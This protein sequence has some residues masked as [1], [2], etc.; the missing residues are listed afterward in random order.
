MIQVMHNILPI[1]IAISASN[2]IP[3]EKWPWW[4]RYNN[5]DCIKYGSVDHYRFPNAC[6]IALETLAVESSKRLDLDEG[7]FPDL[8]FYAGGMH[9]LPP[10]GWL[11]GHYDAEYH[12]LHSWKR[13]GSLVWFANQDWREEWGGQLKIG[14]SGFFPKFNT[15]IYFDTDNCW[16]EV[17]RNVGPD[18]RKTFALFFWKSVSGVP[19]TTWRNA[20]FDKA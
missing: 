12:P 19:D 3:D 11:G 6:R 8:D 10:N 14:E 4:H 5:K 20:K 2:S 1:P 16:H 9:M 7:T 15:A 17:L 18:Y 13:I